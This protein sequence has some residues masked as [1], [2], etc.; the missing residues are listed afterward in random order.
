MS[1]LGRRRCR[2]EDPDVTGPIW[3]EDLGLLVFVV[4]GLLATVRAIA[5]DVRCQL[6]APVAAK[7]GA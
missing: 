2:S 6:R 5:H 1:T 4:G 3:L 7:G